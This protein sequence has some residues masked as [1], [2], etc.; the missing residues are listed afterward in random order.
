VKVNTYPAKQKL[1]QIVKLINNWLPLESKIIFIII[2]YL[3]KTSLLTRIMTSC[4][5]KNCY[6][7]GYRL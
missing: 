4:V 2:I 6:N 5:V 3:F 7:E 1:L